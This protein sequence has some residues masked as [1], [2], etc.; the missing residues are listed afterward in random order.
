MPVV[1][2]VAPD[3]ELVTP[4]TVPS[5]QLEKCTVLP[6]AR[7]SGGGVTEHDEGSPAAPSHS[8]Q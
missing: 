3:E 8:A 7:A 4:F 2:D 6:S 5:V 1:A